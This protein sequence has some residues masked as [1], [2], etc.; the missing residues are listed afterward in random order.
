MGVR[1]VGEE[2]EIEA[3]LKR[4]YSCEQKDSIRPD[5]NSAERELKE[6]LVEVRKKIRFKSN[7]DSKER[8]IERFIEFLQKEPEKPS[9]FSKYCIFHLEN[10]KWGKPG[11]VF[12]DT[13]YLDTGLRVYYK[14]LGEGSGRKWALSPKYKESGV[15]PER[16][17]K[18]A[19]A[20]GVQ[21]RLDVVETSTYENPNWEY[22]LGSRR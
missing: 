11:I 1:E 15:G 19:E 17:A 10:G 22:L 12:L 8:D 16:L 2:E 20:V 14:A 4:R 9:L 7:F 6:E 5:D 18:F 3:I 13:P 21:T